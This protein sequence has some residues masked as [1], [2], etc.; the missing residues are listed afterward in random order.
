[1]AINANSIGLT[2]QNPERAAQIG[3]HLLGQKMDSVEQ[4][5][6][7]GNNSIFKL[8][9]TG[10]DYALK[11]YRQDPKD[12]RDRFVTETAAVKFMRQGGIEDVPELIA[13]DRSSHSALFEWID[14]VK[15]ESPSRSDLDQALSFAETL[16]HLRNL[17]GADDLALASEACLSARDIIEQTRNK[18]DRLQAQPDLNADCRRFLMEEFAPGFAEVSSRQLALIENSGNTPETPVSRGE[19]TLSPSDF[20][21]HNA[22]RQPSGRLTFIDFEYFG[23]DNPI[24]LT[25]DFL[26]HPAMELT[27][28]LRV[29][30]LSEASHLYLE[31][32]RFEQKVHHA[33][34]LY[35]L[36]WCMIVLN[37][38]LPNCSQMQ[39]TDMI[40][41]PD[42][43]LRQKRLQKAQ[44]LLSFAIEYDRGPHA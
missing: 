8:R 43:D 20:G 38:F 29:Y 11:F 6:G 39:S 15:I 24:K 3:T 26:L 5:V 37:V 23:W 13:E 44:E 27:P 41:K 1:L 12:T 18:F 36:R 7:G 4:I 25:C 19:Q 17:A 32:D 9:A 10:Q 28:E 35:G 16:Y 30:F 33:L 40:Q 22:I 31:I 14:G 42:T 2:R 34:P 21:F